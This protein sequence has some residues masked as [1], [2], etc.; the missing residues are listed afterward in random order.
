M[1][2]TRACMRTSVKIYGG[3]RQDTRIVDYRDWVGIPV[4][5]VCQTFHSEVMLRF[6]FQ[7]TKKTLISSHLRNAIMRHS[8]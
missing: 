1:S 4:E 5:Q 6:M 7:V 3:S 2:V 8:D